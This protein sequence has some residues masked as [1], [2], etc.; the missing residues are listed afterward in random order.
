V[1]DV[2][3]LDKIYI[4]EISPRGNPNIRYFLAN[5]VDDLSISDL[6]C[7]PDDPDELEEARWISVES[8]FKLEKFR[9]QRKDVLHFALEAFDDPEKFIEN[10]P[11]VE[12]WKGDILTKK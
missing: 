12:D 9:S 7:V 11:L 10:Y 4:D 5:V 1:K 8:A 6:S 2:E 3:F